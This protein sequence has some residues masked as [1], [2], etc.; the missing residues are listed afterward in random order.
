MS[1]GTILISLSVLLAYLLGSVPFGFLTA[2]GVGGIDIREHGSRN[3]GA[4][5]VARVLGGRWGA[6]V[7]VL[8]CLKGFLATLLLP[9][10]AL[11]GDHP[12]LG[13]LR[14]ACG[15]MAVLGHMF[16]CWLGF[17]G[18]KGVATALGVVVVLG[19]TATLVAF[20]TFALSFAAFRIVS[21]SSM[22][23]AVA[24]AAC[25]MWLLQPDPFSPDLWSVSLFSLLVPVLIIVRHRTNL[26]R[27][28]RGQEPKF[29]TAVANEE[30]DDARLSKQRPVE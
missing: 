8:D 27:L 6:I 3:V 25:Q 21:L 14:V 15:T 11:L 24:F 29:R 10:I 7:L 2:R 1:S 4:T 19:P 18:G 17:R 12:G 9:S 22:L 30:P 28:W 16:P 26:V 23:A 20:A 5:N 13:H